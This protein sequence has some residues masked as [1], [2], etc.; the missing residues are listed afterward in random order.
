MK[1][2]VISQYG[3]PEVLKLQDVEIASPGRGQ[4]LVRLAM[5]GVNFVDIHQR[6]GTYPPT[7]SLHS[8]IGGVGIV[9]KV[10]EGVTNVKPGDRVAI[11]DSLE[12]TLKGVWFRR[13][14]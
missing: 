8:G 10:G 7:T 14:V 13:I 9:E 5:A 3:G 6:R 12:R 11:P 1:A 2:I 4:A